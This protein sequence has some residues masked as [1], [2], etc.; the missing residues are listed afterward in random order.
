MCESLAA[1]AT[2]DAAALVQAI[3]VANRRV[4]AEAT[5]DPNL[6]GMGTTV[7]AALDMGEGTFAVASVGDSRAYLMSEGVL[8]Q[9]TEDQ[10]WI[11]EVGAPLGLDAETL[12]T[13]PMRHVLTMAVGASPDLRVRYYSV[14]LGPG[15]LVLLSSD[16]LHGV[17]AEPQ[18]ESILKTRNGHE[19]LASRCQSLVEAAHEAG[20][21]DNVT[22][23]L[24]T[25]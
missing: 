7:V 11:H 17:V 14:R 21:P 1:A 8:R 18:I 3:E 24:V 2:G 12:R 23:V 9:I 4:L 6:E 19:T 15:D 25:V 13:H 5:R 20:S 22:V 16:G 10:T